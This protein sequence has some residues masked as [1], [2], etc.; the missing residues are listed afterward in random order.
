MGVEEL[1]LNCKRQNWPLNDEKGLLTGEIE[2][3]TG[4]AG[5]DST[6]VTR[7]QAFSFPESRPFSASGT[8]DSC[9]ALERSRRR[10]PGR[11]QGSG[12]PEILTLSVSSL[13]FK[14]GGWL[15]GGGQEAERSS[16]LYL[17]DL[18][19]LGTDLV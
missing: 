11:W 1:I 19:F 13:S 14:G 18:C 12:V 6:L 2:A 3:A 5:P 4:S 7:R 10:E 16:C 15:W 8:S 17:W 9:S